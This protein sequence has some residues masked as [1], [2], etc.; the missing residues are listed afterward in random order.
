MLSQETFQNTNAM[1]GINTQF[2]IFVEGNCHY[3]DIEHNQTWFVTIH[4]C[5]V[6]NGTY[7]T[8][9]AFN[10][11]QISARKSNFNN[12]CW[13]D[14][15]QP[16]HFIMIMRVNCN[17]FCLYLESNAMLHSVRDITWMG[18]WLLHCTQWS[19]KWH[20]YKWCPVTVILSKK[21]QF[22]DFQDCH[23]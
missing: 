12:H 13:T 3:S 1:C 16:I 6:A 7:L 21:D 2:I 10:S 11:G 18:A 14:W 17:S 23:L 15:C 20:S 8:R 5:Y 9:S 4:S 22:R 19:T